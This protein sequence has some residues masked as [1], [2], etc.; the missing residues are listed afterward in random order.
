MIQS[1]M[2]VIGDAYI[3]FCFVLKISKFLIFR[4]KVY[5]FYVFGLK[6]F[7][8]FLAEKLQG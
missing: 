1:V 2:S 3:P 7:G 8:F 5:M 6:T 4:V